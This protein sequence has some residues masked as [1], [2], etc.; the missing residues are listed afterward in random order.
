MQYHKAISTIRGILGLS[1]QDFA[2]AT[3]FSK[4]YISRIENK[5]RNPSEDAVRKM[6]DKLDIS[7]NLFH[8]L[9]QEVK[10][11]DL[12]IAQEI[13]K[14]MLELLGRHEKQDK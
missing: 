7:E 3:G 13:G 2:K 1:V 6:A 12:E 14:N 8:L 5:Q 10:N 9:A 11:T 4:S